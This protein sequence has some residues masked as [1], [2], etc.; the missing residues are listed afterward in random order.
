MKSKER[1]GG[2]QVWV[3]L[4]DDH[5]IKTP[6]KRNEIEEDVKRYLKKKGQ[7]HKLE[8][9]LGKLSSDIETSKKIILKS[10]IP[11]KYL[12]F[13]EFLDEGKTKQKKVINLGDKIQ[14]L[15][16]EHKIKEAKGLIDKFIKFNQKLWTYGIHEMPMKLHSS[17]GVLNGKIVLIDLFELNSNKKSVARRL[18]KKPWKKK[19]PLQKIFPESI[20]EYYSKQADKNLTVDNLDKLWKSKK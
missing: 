10:K 7:I 17:F 18:R 12:A 16:K 8:E 20:V 4:Y 6:K 2:W 9:T 13:P 14:G 15:L 11:K 1:K 19:S 5:V 3:D